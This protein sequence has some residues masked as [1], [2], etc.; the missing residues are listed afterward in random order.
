MIIKLDNEQMLLDEDIKLYNI[1]EYAE[2]RATVIINGKI[3]TVKEFREMKQKDT[4]KNIF[5]RK[6]KYEIGD[7]L[8]END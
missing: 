2:S 1:N 5:G 3:I 6:A 7:N 4:K 8:Y